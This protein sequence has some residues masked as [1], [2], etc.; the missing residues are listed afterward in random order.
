[1]AGYS[2]LFAIATTSSM[3]PRPL[4][5]LNATPALC[6]HDGGACAWHLHLRFRACDLLRGAARWSH[7]HRVT[8]L[9]TCTYGAGA[10]NPIESV[11]L[12][13]RNELDRYRG[14]QISGSRCARFQFHATSIVIPAKVIIIYIVMGGKERLLPCTLHRVDECATSAT[15]SQCRSARAHPVHGSRCAG[16]YR[17]LA[18]QFSHPLACSLPFP[19]GR[20]LATPQRLPYDA[21]YISILNFTMP[22]GIPSHANWGAF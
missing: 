2:R 18:R 4:R 13:A 17:L 6:P 11:V 16:G 5:S 3:S 8:L 15:P 9:E 22:C 1:M 20:F 7:C 10:S 21:T 19:R 12:G 14:N